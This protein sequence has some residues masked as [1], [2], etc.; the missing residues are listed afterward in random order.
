MATVFSPIRGTDQAKV[1]RV[2]EVTYLG[3]VN[4]TMTA[5]RRMQLGTIV[6]VSS[7]LTWRAM[8]VKSA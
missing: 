1:R 7:V 8:P 5:L 2:T 3:A 6:Q 4:G